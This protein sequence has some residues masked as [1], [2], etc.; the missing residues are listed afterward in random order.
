MFSVEYFRRYRKL[1]E[2]AQEPDIAKAEPIDQHRIKRHFYLAAGIG[3]SLL[4]PDTSEVP[5][6]QV[7]D[8]VSTG[9]QI[10]LGVDVNR[11]FAVELHA[12]DLGSAGLSPRGRINYEE[13]GASALIYAGKNRG[14]YKRQGQT[15]YGRLG[16][17]SINNSAEGDVPFDQTNS[18]HLLIGVGL[19]YMTQVG[20][21]LRAEFISYEEDVQYA[22][23]ALVYRLGKRSRPETVALAQAAPAQDTIVATP[24]PPLAEATVEQNGAAS[25]YP[26][27]SVYFPSDSAELD[28]QSKQTIAGIAETL[29]QCED[30]EVNLVGYTDDIGSQRYNDAPDLQAQVTQTGMIIRTC[31]LRPVKQSVLSAY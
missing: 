12:A 30:M 7:N 18:A 14:R 10:T 25:T 6:F 17:G 8:K 21:G 3:K 22:Q 31:T 24:E 20:L 1:S 28:V 2:T 4:E 11:I 23:L 26:A 5:E 19:E 27:V 29:T 13:Y 15:G 9:A 16:V